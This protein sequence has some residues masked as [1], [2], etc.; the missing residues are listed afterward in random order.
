MLTAN[1]SGYPKRPDLESIRKYLDVGGENPFTTAVKNAVQ[2]QIKAKIDI[3]TDGQIRHPIPLLASNVPGMTTDGRICIKSKLGAPRRPMMTLDFL[4]AAAECED[5]RLVKAV[6]PGP[7]S[8]VKSCE[9]DAKSPYSSRYNVDLLFDI[10]SII[11]F[12]IDALKES[13]ARLIQIVEPVDSVKDI[14]IFLDLLSFL[15]RR[16]KTPI[17]HVEGDVS[18]AFPQLLDAKISVI[19]LDVVAFPQNREILK[20][21]E[22]FEVHDKILSLGCIDSS[23]SKKESLESIE[24]R[25]IA[26]VRAFGYESVWISPNKTL[27]SLSSR[28]AFHKLEQLASAKNHFATE[29]P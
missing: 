19:S 21:E 18:V 20:F 6:L 11:R 3:V 27:E 13:K 1:L 2:S 29:T 23:A 26:F 16:V 22:L 7:F 14:D 4:T 25:A 5:T 10:A 8:F 17:C 24:K 15:F 9:L 28:A 12:E